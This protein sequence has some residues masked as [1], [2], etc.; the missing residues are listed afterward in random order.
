ME[1]PSTPMSRTTKVNS[2]TTASTEQT[3]AWVHSYRSRPSSF[4]WEASSCPAC[5]SCFFFF[6]I[7]SK[8]PRALPP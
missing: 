5:A 2:S 3:R 7:A 4:F 1:W 8:P 6:H